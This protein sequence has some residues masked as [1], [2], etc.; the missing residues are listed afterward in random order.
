MRTSYGWADALIYAMSSAQMNLA[1]VIDSYYGLD[2]KTGDARHVKN[3]MICGFLGRQC[4]GN[5]FHSN[6]QILDIS[7]RCNAGIFACAGD[8]KRCF[9]AAGWRIIAAG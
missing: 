8:C 9:C 5:G 6:T 4:V 7:W 1:C 2:C 3:E